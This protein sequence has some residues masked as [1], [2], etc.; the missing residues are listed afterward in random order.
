MS[1]AINI[2]GK[3][4]ALPD[5][6]QYATKE[7]VDGLNY[8]DKVTLVDN[9]AGYQFP[10]IGT[11]IPYGIVFTLPQRLIDGGWRIV[12]CSLFEVKN[13]YDQREFAVVA[14]AFTMQDATQV[15]LYFY[16]ATSQFIVKRVAVT[17]TIAR[18]AP[19]ATPSP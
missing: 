1:K 8:A 19:A 6:S 14:S 9:N 15:K 5:L 13:E 3:D 4:A 7:Y 10:E 18:I 16:S 2:R 12:G 17:A 11:G